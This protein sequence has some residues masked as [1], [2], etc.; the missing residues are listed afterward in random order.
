MGFYLQHKSSNAFKT[1]FL[2]S[3]KRIPRRDYTWNR[4]QKD[5]DPEH[6]S[7]SVCILALSSCSW[8]LLWLPLGYCW[9]M[10]D[11]PEKDV[12]NR[13]VRKERTRFRDDDHKKKKKKKETWKIMKENSWWLI[14]NEEERNRRRAQ[15]HRIFPMKGLQRKEIMCEI[16]CSLE[17]SSWF[18]YF[19]S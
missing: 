15:T 18:L 4:V 7:F 13:D 6:L 2:R 1:R 3:Q 5:K 11:W 14:W 19:Y 9:F 16:F 12:E 8:N 10:N 17:I